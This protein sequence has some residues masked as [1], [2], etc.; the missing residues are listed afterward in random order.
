MA[1]SDPWGKPYRIVMNK[2]GN[3]SAVGKE[4]IIADHLFPTATV[5]DWSLA[6]PTYSVNLFE[7]FDPDTDTLPY[8]MVIPPFTLDELQN[9]SKRLSAGKAGGSSGVPN[10]ALK[11]LVTMRPHGVLRSYNNCL[12]ALHFPQQWKKAKL[13]LLHKGTGKPVESPSSF[14]PICLLDTPGKLLE[15]LLLQ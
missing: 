8:E 13:V 15:R 2:A 7:A 10:E 1:E 14:R 4:A 5:T 3:N 9:A 12:S 11:Q 6:P